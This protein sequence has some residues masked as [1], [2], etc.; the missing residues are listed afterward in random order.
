MDCSEDAEMPS[1]N[2]REVL[3][4]VQLRQWDTTCDKKKSDEHAPR[5]L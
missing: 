2:V 4:V 1:G 3:S 5:K